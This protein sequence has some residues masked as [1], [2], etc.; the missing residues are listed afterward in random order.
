MEGMSILIRYC[1]H[2]YI[3]WTHRRCRVNVCSTLWIIYLELK[4]TQRDEKM[5]GRAEA[6]EC[7][8]V[9]VF[10]TMYT[11]SRC[12]FANMC[13]GRRMHVL[14][15]TMA[16]HSIIMDFH[17]V[18]RTNANVTMLDKWYSHVLES[19]QS[20]VSYLAIIFD[21]NRITAAANV[22]KSYSWINR[23][24][25][26]VVFV[27]FVGV[28]FGCILMDKYR[29]HWSKSQY[30]YNI[31]HWGNQTHYPPHLIYSQRR[32]SVSWYAGFFSHSMTLLQ[33]SIHFFFFF[34]FFSRSSSIAKLRVWVC[35]AC[36]P[37]CSH[38]L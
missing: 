13:T 15:M 16:R 30:E 32:P 6:R 3:S 35:A 8:S 20:C 14:M 17:F 34:I 25:I 5:N 22:R 31:C 38:T 18:R 21:K 26:S 33:Q 10:D 28:G 29:C 24:Y 37:P 1:T 27:L 19:H 9:R 12:K 7:R 36:A 2:I 4:H 23:D 11:W